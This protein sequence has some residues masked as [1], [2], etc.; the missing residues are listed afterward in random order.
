MRARCQ[1]LPRPLTTLHFLPS[2]SRTG[3]SFLTGC[4]WEGLIVEEGFGAVKGFGPVL[5]GP[6]W[7]F[8]VGFLW[9]FM[10]SD[11]CFKPRRDT[12]MS[13]QDWVI[14]VLDSKASTLCRN[15]VVS[16]EILLHGCTF[17][18]PLYHYGTGSH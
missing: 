1:G 15:L 18:S 11:T 10:S 2:S 3:G 16:V 9:V 7:F 17:H 8:S 5:I 4:F 6:P 14:K 12:A 13:F